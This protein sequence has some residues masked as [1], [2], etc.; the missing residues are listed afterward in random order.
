MAF[1]ASLTALVSQQLNQ[2]LSR[3]CQDYNLPAEEVLPRY[4]EA[5]DLPAPAKKAPA[6][7]AAAKK[8]ADRPMCL[9][10][11]KGLPCKHKSQVGDELCH[12]HKKQRDSPKPEKE[13]K[14]PCRGTTSKGLPC[15][16]KA[17]AG[18]DLCHLHLAK[19]NRPVPAKGA[20]KK[21][22]SPQPQVA[23][24]GVSPPPVFC[25][26]CAPAPSQEEVEGDMNAD[27]ED[28]QARLAR[29][30]L[31]ATQTEEEQGE[32][33]EQEEQVEQEEQM[34]Q[35]EQEEQVEFRPSCE[36]LE[37]NGMADDPEDWDNDQ[38]ESPHSRDLLDR[39][40]AFNVKVEEEDASDQEIGS[41]EDEFLEE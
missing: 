11:V 30:M 40:K 22:P 17:Q 6:K 20:S 3:V 4:L 32:Q 7:K 9:G 37:A 10:Q 2:L 23:G 33:E 13:P 25:E 27:M 16:V 15:T 29:I 31:G 38:M 5:Q 18:C 26:P 19:S 39:L 24:R 21:S 8:A 34:E 28:V 1:Q 12:I 41:E 14:R 35:M 36:A